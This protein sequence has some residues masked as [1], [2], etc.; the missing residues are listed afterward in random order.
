MGQKELGRKNEGHGKGL[1]LTLAHLHTGPQDKFCPE[2]TSCLP[3]PMRPQRVWKRQGLGEL[4]MVLLG[5]L[6]P[7]HQCP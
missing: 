6:S 2:L 5:L 7:R 1:L 4:Q 3:D